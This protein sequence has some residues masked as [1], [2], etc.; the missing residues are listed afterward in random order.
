MGDIQMLSIAESPDEAYHI[1]LR[2]APDCLS[3]HSHSPA[4]HTSRT[5]SSRSS[6]RTASRGSSKKKKQ[7]VSSSQ[8][9][10]SSAGV[11]SNYSYASNRHN[12]QLQVNYAASKGGRTSLNDL[13]NRAEGRQ[14]TIVSSR[15]NQTQNIAPYKNVRANTGS[16]SKFEALDAA[17]YN[18]DY[19]DTIDESF[20]DE[21]PGTPKTNSN[22]ATER[23]GKNSK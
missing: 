22:L 4:K 1:C 16:T 12:E 6:S 13:G 8:E 19:F 15:P 11:G 3:K 20:Y 23:K 17:S 9:V 7:N 10:R 2:Y 5:S 14:N 21:G 18:D